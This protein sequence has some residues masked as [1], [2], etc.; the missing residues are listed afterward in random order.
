[1]ICVSVMRG[2]VNGSLEE[3]LWRGV[4]TRKFPGQV[5]T[6]YLYP[7][8][9]FGLWHLSFFPSDQGSVVFALGVTFLGAGYGWVAWRIRFVLGL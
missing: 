7:A 8:L 9:A 1:M 3:I 5:L 4:Y 6:G 2:L